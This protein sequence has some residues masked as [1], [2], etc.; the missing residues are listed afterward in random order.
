M[1]F[2]RIKNKTT[3]KLFPDKKKKVLILFCRKKGNMFKTVWFGMGWVEMNISAPFSS[4]YSKKKKMSLRFLILVP[5]S[6]DPFISFVTDGESV[7]CL[8]LT[9]SFH[10]HRWGWKGTGESL[11][12]DMCHP[13]CFFFCFFQLNSPLPSSLSHSLWQCCISPFCAFPCFSLKLLEVWN[14]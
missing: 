8:G 1:N 7:P 10:F 9:L 2:K 4:F 5:S 3:K 14:F 13:L 11:L 12:N 6:S